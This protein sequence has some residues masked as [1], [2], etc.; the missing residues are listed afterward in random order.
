MHQGIRHL[1]EVSVQLQL[2]LQGILNFYKQCKHISYV[3]VSLCDCILIS[4]I[5]ILI[6]NHKFYVIVSLYPYVIK[7]KHISYVICIEIVRQSKKE[8]LPLWS[9]HLSYLGSQPASEYQQPTIRSTIIKRNQPLTD[10]TQVNG[11]NVNSSGI[12]VFVLISNSFQRYFKL[13]MLI[14][15][16]KLSVLWPVLFM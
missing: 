2:V 9:V 11:V 3:I 8:M 14:L 12:A 1:E 16:Q 15:F 13:I 10:Q 4:L 6:S 5:C 7:Y